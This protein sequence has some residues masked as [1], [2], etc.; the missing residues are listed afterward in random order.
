[1]KLHG[2]GK[3]PRDPVSMSFSAP[4][5]GAGRTQSR[6]LFGVHK[7]LGAQIAR[8][9]R[10]DAAPLVETTNGADIFTKVSADPHAMNR[11]FIAQDATAAATDQ[12]PTA[13][14]PPARPLQTGLVRQL[15][16][17]ARRQALLQNNPQLDVD[18]GAV[19]FTSVGTDSELDDPCALV[20][21]LREAR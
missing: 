10:D 4:T 18:R 1:M 3:K 14:S 21:E 13:L 19:M 9:A 20:H 7:I 5:R 11:E 12:P 6:S 2:N 17:L 8:L 16:T 15:S